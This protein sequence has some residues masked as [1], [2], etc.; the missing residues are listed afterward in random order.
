M[1]SRCPAIAPCCRQQSSQLYI[2]LA[3]SLEATQQAVWYTYLHAHICL[4]VLCV[5]FDMCA[6]TAPSGSRAKQ[7]QQQEEAAQQAAL[8][9]L[10]SC[11]C[12]GEPLQPALR[13][14]PPVNKMWTLQSPA[15]RTRSSRSARRTVSSS[16]TPSSS[17]SQAR[18]Q[19]PAT[20]WV[21]ARIG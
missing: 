9:Q 7:C 16:P 18:Q 6:V 15:Q 21:Q 19:A 4:R 11:T 12:T 14:L 1:S 5:S 10:T 8:L 3:T 20:G 17:P 13:C 2:W